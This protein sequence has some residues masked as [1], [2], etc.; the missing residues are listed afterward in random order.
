MHKQCKW[1]GTALLLGSAQRLIEP[2]TWA[3]PTHAMIPAVQQLKVKEFYKLDLYGECTIHMWLYK[4]LKVLLILQQA[5]AYFSA[6]VSTNI[7]GALLIVQITS[8]ILV[9]K[10]SLL[11]DI[12]PP[13]RQSPYCLA[14]ISFFPFSPGDRVSIWVDAFNLWSVNC[15]ISCRPFELQL[16]R[17]KWFCGWKCLCLIPV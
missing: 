9:S 2:K 6:F 15:M 17:T 4:S 10:M 11:G 16:K 1:E 14:Y 8:E 13:P 7:S 12:S 3:V 5:D